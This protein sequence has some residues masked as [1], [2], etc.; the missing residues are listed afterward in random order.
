V[1]R[2]VSP[3]V[4]AFSIDPGNPSGTNRTI[5]ITV[6]ANV[7]LTRLSNATVRTQV[8]ITG[9][10]TSFGFPATECA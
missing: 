5:D 4:T 6:L 9:R 3:T 7:S 8:A 2:A 1:N 10:D